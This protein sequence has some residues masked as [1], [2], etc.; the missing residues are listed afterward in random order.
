MLTFSFFV[1]YKL[2]QSEYGSASPK[3]MSVITHYHL[4]NRVCYGDMEPCHVLTRGS[5]VYG[6]CNSQV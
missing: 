2:C 4:M 3:E 5:C 6:Y 1:K